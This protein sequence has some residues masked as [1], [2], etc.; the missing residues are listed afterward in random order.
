MSFG[1]GDCNANA[2][3][4]EY[5]EDIGAH[6]PVMDRVCPNLTTAYNALPTETDTLASQGNYGDPYNAPAE[7]QPSAMLTPVSFPD[8]SY[9]A[10]RTSPVL[11]HH[12]QEY[13]YPVS[14][15]VGHRGLGITTPYPSELTG[16]IN[17]GLGIAPSGYAVGE[18]T[19]S[20]QPTRKRPRG[21]SKQSLTREPPVTILPHPE[22][23]QRLE[24]QRR[25][26]H[27]DPGSQRRPPGRGRKDSKQAEEEDDF[28]E[29]LR[30]QKLAWR[31][32][33][34]MFREKYKKDASEASLQMR[35]S[36]RRKE[37]LTRWGEHDVRECTA[38]LSDYCL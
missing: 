30:E 14:D 23:V 13:Q 15:S 34:D 16:N 20:P 10:T 26:S 35:Q 9:T 17:Y 3:M 31:V 11:S 12:S 38:A 27:I 32:I 21:E 5:F 4:D 37:R 7:Y 25:Q 18:K 19:I 6:W 22:G 1:P 2:G 28:V 36:R 29:H 8:A 33:Q 24:E